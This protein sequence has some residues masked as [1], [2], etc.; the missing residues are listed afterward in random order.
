[1]ILSIMVGNHTETLS[2]NH[3]LARAVDLFDL[4]TVATIPTAQAGM[5]LSSVSLY[6]GLIS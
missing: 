1:M 4:F 2:P 3:K 6:S 5:Y